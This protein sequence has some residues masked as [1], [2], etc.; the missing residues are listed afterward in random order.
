MIFFNVKEARNQLIN[1]M[2]VYTLR[3]SF[4]AIGKTLAVTGTLS[5]QRAIY[6]VNVQRIMN[7]TCAE[8]LEPYLDYSGFDNVHEWLGAAAPSAR[9]LYLVTKWEEQKEK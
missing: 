3:S 2:K 4:R 7:I 9:T 6:E 8:E 1:S 5:N